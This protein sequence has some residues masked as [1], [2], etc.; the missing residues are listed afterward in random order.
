MVVLVQLD[1]AV[2]KMSLS[3][4]LSLSLVAEKPRLTKEITC[5]ILRSNTLH[6]LTLTGSIHSEGD[7]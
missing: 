2:E 7:L 6:S 1:V 5:F 3:L 4:S